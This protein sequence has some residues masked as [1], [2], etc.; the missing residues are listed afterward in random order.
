MRKVNLLVS[1]VIKILEKKWFVFCAADNKEF[2]STQGSNSLTFI[3]QVSLVKRFWEF[4]PKLL[5]FLFVF[6]VLPTKPLLCA[7]V[8]RFNVSTTLR[9]LSN[10]IVG[11]HA[12]QL[13]TSYSLFKSL[14]T[15][16]C[17]YTTHI[18]SYS[19]YYSLYITYLYYSQP[20]TPSPKRTQFFTQIFKY[21]Q[22]SNKSSFG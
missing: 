3:P 11:I 8:L 18:F 12:W 9:C 5:H 16:I 14:I 6:F 7:Y 19:C 1:L 22:L 17:F 13:Y 15:N 4:F 2:F 20:T 10:C 21:L